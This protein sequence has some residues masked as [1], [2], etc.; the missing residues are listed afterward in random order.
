MKEKKLRSRSW[1][2]LHLFLV[3]SSS[4][5][6]PLISLWFPLMIFFIR[7]ISCNYFVLIQRFDF[8]LLVPYFWVCLQEPIW[9]IWFLLCDGNSFMN[10]GHGNEFWFWYMSIFSLIP[11]W[12]TNTYI[13]AL[14]SSRIFFFFVCAHPFCSEILNPV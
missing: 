13:H 11:V 12:R 10:S 14:V 2:E 5:L 4:Y 7:F 9:A 6:C 8:H 3:L 1:S